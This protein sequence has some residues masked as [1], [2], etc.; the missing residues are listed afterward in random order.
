M[1]WHRKTLVMSVAA[2]LF[3]TCVCGAEA[4]GRRNQGP[5]QQPGGPGGPGG[6]PQG[7]P[8][9]GPGGFGG[10]GGMGG[11]FGGGMSDIMIL[12]R[13]DVQK[14][15]ELVDD[16]IE[17]LGKLRDNNDMRRMFEQVRD[18]PQEERGAKMREIMETAQAAVKEALKNILLEHQQVRFKQLTMQWQMRGGGGLASSEDVAKEL[19]ISDEQR[20]KLRTK[21]R[22]LER[23]MRKKLLEDLLK[24]LTPEQQAKYK[25]LVGEPFEFQQDERFG[26]GRG[27]QF[28]P[29][30]GGRGDGGRGNGGRRGGN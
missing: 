15:L 3:L 29:G 6:P 8:G 12:A 18:L 7:G 30:G 21:A 9:G 5:G 16:Q 2:L 22:E 20:E 19:G 17:Q 23:A 28:G 4:Q 14:E 13:E 1:L 11:F 25:E 27:G 24:E 26:P 10:P